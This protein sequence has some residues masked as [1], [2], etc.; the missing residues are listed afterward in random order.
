MGDSGYHEA[1]CRQ[2]DKFQNQCVLGCRRDCVYF[3][4]V[5]PVT[6]ITETLVPP[7]AGFQE[8]QSHQLQALSAALSQATGR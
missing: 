4:R 6:T 7:S 8:W 3:R 5:H 1:E 2:R